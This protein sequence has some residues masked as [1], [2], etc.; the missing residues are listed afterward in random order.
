MQLSVSEV[1]FDFLELL[2]PVLGFFFFHSVGL[3]TYIL[4][5]DGYGKVKYMYNSA[6]VSLELIYASYKSYQEHS[7]DLYLKTELQVVSVDM[8]GYNI[9]CRYRLRRA[10]LL[11]SSIFHKKS[12]SKTEKQSFNYS[13]CSGIYLPF[14]KCL[15]CVKSYF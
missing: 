14:N 6:L 1:G 5:R 3:E 7:D 13:F 2:L 8:S 10:C 15:V 12:F 9:D 4:T 11:F